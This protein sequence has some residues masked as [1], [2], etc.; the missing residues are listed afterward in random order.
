MPR[1]TRLLIYFNLLVFLLQIFSADGLLGN[2]ALWPPGQHW[3]PELQRWVGFQPWQ[4]LT[5]AFLHGS[6]LHIALNMFALWMFGSEVEL[7]LGKHYYLGLYLMAVLSA[8]LTQL[9]VVSMAGDG[10]YPTVG[11]SGGVFG[12][13]LAFGL[14]FPRRTIYLLIPPVPLPAIVAVFL[15]ASIELV[16][17]VM[18][19]ASG[20]AHFAH[21]GGMLGGF[22]TLRFWR[23][24]RR[25]R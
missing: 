2:Y 17:G 11:A 13:L 15:F 19:T 8:S 20:V 21:L 23:G 1:I 24:K 22:L 18:G 3:S 12:V 7:R 6:L 16:S 9:I 25:V 14:L 10:V 5:S 4:L